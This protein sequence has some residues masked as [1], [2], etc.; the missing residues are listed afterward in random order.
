[1]QIPVISGQDDN[2]FV[3]QI[4]HTEI[5]VDEKVLESY[6][7][8]YQLAPTFKITVTREG[9]KLFAQATDQPRFQIFAESPTDFFYKVVDAQIT[10]VKDDKGS[11]TQLIMHQGGQNI[12][13]KK[14]K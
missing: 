4:P 7:G 12:P 9:D 6:V 5:P 13:G 11:V 1:M 14:I 10:F 8:D 3:Q 2:I